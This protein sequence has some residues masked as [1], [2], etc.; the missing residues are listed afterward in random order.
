M[1]LRALDGMDS[2]DPRKWQFAEQFA[3][4]VGAQF[5]QG[6]QV[7]QNRSGGEI[8]LRGRWN[9]IP[10][11]LKFGMSF[12]DFEWEMQASN[13]S[14]VELMLHYDPKAV[15]DVGQF[16]GAVADDWG[17]NSDVKTFFAKGYYLQVSKGGLDRSL[18][19]YQSLP[20]GVRSSLARFMV[21]DQIHHLYAY[22]RGRLLLDNFDKARDSADPLNHV[23]R[24]VW[25]AG[26]VAWG[27]GQLN[28]SKL[29]ATSQAAAPGLLHKMT[30]GYCRTLY[31]WSQNQFCPNCGAPPRA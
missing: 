3:N 27:L 18:A 15:P 19:A 2:Q 11:R 5:L 1:N 25:L 31:L 7:V 13:P 10:V 20:E 8:E 22:S 21:A 28:P 24:G 4:S 30:C 17:D 23:G 9:D 26:Q 29:P 14:G 16:S 12:G 6:H